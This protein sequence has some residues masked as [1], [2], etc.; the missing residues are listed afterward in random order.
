M[1][2][3]IVRVEDYV[4]NQPVK[5]IVLTPSL[6]GEAV[7]FKHLRDSGVRTLRVVFTDQRELRIVL[8]DTAPLS[9]IQ[10]PVEKGR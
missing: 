7:A 9:G 3:R 1:R 2:G 5:V 8:P 6:G 10:I 4:T